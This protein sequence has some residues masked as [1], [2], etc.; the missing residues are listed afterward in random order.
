VLAGEVTVRRKKSI[1]KG[2]TECDL[3]HI[4]KTCEER[5]E[6]LCGVEI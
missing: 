6:E 1:C 2:Q 5:R 3:N 4:V